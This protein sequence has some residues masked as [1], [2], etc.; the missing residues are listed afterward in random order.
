[1]GKG[2]GQS[3]YRGVRKHYTLWKAVL[4]DETVLGLYATP[5]DA[6]IVRERFLHEHRDEFKEVERYLNHVDLA[7]GVIINTYRKPKKVKP[8][9]RQPRYGKYVYRNRHHNSFFVR[10]GNYQSKCFPF[11]SYAIAHRDEYLQNNRK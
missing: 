2:I 6:A 7:P 10:I 8:Q 3:G 1:M 4:P 9:K 5:L 11:V